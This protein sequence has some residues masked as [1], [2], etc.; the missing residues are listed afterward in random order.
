MAGDPAPQISGIA[1]AYHLGE[2]IV[3]EV[4]VDAADEVTV[5]LVFETSG[6]C[7]P[8]RAVLRQ[9]VSGPCTGSAPFRLDGPRWPP[10]YEGTLFAGNW[11]LEVSAT[12]GG[13]RGSAR[14]EV[15]VDAAGLGIE[16]APVRAASNRPSGSARRSGRGVR[17]VVLAVLE[18]A[19]IV[20]VVVG[21][22]TGSPLW[23]V[24]LVVGLAL[25]L[26]LVGTVQGFLAHRVAGSLSGHVEQHGD[27]LVVHVELERVEAVESVTASLRVVEATQ[28]GVGYDHPE[29]RRH[30]VHRHDTVLE[31]VG[32][33]ADGGP[34]AGGGFAGELAL[35]GDGR[36]PCTIGHS[37]A[38]VD[39][40]VEVRAVLG[41]AP[42]IVD[43]LAIVARPQRP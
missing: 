41:G 1:E 13:R 18:V 20:A 15:T 34:G 36:V 27:V 8:E 37:S 25:V 29:S 4:L 31:P 23:A 7:D 42:D 10:T 6:S 19:S 26:P 33:G 21:A 14:R 28:R 12:V 3:G 24:G 16:V 40:S 5:A 9:V 35:P 2:V 30:L 11:Y 39:W 38:Q 43:E 17:L 22:I 32:D